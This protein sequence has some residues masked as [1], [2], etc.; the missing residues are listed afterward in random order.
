MYRGYLYVYIMGLSELIYPL[1]IILLCL[2]VCL[3]GD[4][5]ICLHVIPVLLRLD[6]RLVGCLGGRLR[7]PLAGL[8]PDRLVGCMGGPLRYLLMDLL[9]G[10]LVGRLNGH[11]IVRF[12]R[13]CIVLRVIW[14]RGRDPSRV[15][16]AGHGFISVFAALVNFSQYLLNCLWSSYMGR[17][18]SFPRPPHLRQCL[19]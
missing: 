7:C 16:S 6:C 14:D 19:V 10:H 18:V 9:A 12:G 13:I 11:L 1:V 2:L 15:G 3:M 5:L 4:P 17:Q 8:L